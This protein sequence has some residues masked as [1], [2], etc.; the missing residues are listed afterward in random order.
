MKRGDRNE[1]RNGPA[2]GENDTAAEFNNRNAIEDGWY[3][4]R[5]VQ[6]RSLAATQGLAMIRKRSIRLRFI[7]RMAC[8]AQRGLGVTEAAGVGTSMDNRHQRMQKQCIAKG[9]T[10]YVSPLQIMRNHTR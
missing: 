9:Q 2:S 5:S 1:G 4:R 10:Q 7:V 3:H 6:P 8:Q